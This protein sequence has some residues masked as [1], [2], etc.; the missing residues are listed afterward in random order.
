VPDQ[1]PLARLPRRVRERLEDLAIA[2]EAVPAEQIA[3][4]GA[5]PIDET[6]HQQARDSAD[7]IAAGYGWSDAVRAARAAPMAW[8]DHQLPDSMTWPMSSG[9]RSQPVTTVADR[10]RIAQSL[11]DAVRAVAL[12]DDLNEDDRDELVGPWAVLIEAE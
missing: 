10:V 12:W 1:D 2:L 3:L 11:A 8:L 5:R 6:R 7:E 9:A 4:L